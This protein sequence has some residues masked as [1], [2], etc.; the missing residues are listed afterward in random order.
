MLIDRARI[1]IK[2]GDGGNGSTSF[3]REKYVPRGGPDGGDGG[4][5]GDVRLRV[6]TNVT[7][8]LKFQFNQR[9]GAE[10][11]GAGMKQQKHGKSGVHL[12]ID[13]PPGTVVWDDETDELLADL[14]EPDEEVTLSRG[15]RGGLG[16]THFKSSTRQAPRLAELG[17]PGL[18][19]WLRLELR[20]VADVGLVGLPNAGKST[21]LAAATAARPKVADYPFTT[22]EPNLGVVEVG[23]TGGQAFVLADIPG[24]IEG[25]AEGAGLGHEFLR[26][27]R[28]TKVLVHVLDASGGLEGR[29]ALVDYQTIAAEVAA[30]DDEMAG[31]PRLVALNK[32]DLAEGREQVARLRSALDG[33]GYPIFEVSAATG[34][35]V[36]DL[37]QAV[38]A[39]LR[40]VELLAIEAEKPQERRRYTLESVDERAWQVA[41]ITPGHFAVT[42]VGI[43]R[44]ARM[45]NFSLDDA[46]RRF[47][48]TLDSS[49]ISAELKRQGVA[50]GDTVHIGGHEMVWGRQDEPEPVGV[51]RRRRAAVV[52]DAQ[53]FEFP[54][55][56]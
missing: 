12:Y 25:A 16:N 40:E 27:V 14:T 49:G 11:G 1:W 33:F 17:E 43:E 34:V 15:G 6:K 32:V 42:G 41:T 39:E 52:D 28:R 13:V 18:E 2:A 21:L 4:R 51:S 23:G 35:G 30:Y 31:K 19:H 48:R 26:H 22:L 53:E 45:T 38:A 8:L 37:M 56:E 20:M 5:G 24:L 46:V 55:D 47:Q 36:P 3:R 10:N 29:D 54:E 44:F 7:S 50:S 9:F